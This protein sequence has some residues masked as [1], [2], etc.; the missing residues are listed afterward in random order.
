MVAVLL[1][2]GQH[3]PALLAEAP[4]GTPLQL[5]RLSASC[6]YHIAT[7]VLLSVMSPSRRSSMLFS[8]S[9]ADLYPLVP[10]HKLG[11]ISLANTDH[12]QETLL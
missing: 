5:H 11:V 1:K 12:V 7:L 6:S 9:H 8:Q 3:G 10:F 4:C 2:Q